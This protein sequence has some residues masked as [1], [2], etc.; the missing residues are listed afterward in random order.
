MVDDCTSDS[1]EHGDLA[2]MAQPSNADSSL[3]GALPDELLVEIFEQ[4]PFYNL[5]HTATF[6]SLCLVSKRIDLIARPYLFKNI[7]IR[8]TAKLVRLHRTI[9][10]NQHLCEHIKDLTIQFYITDQ[11][12]PAVREKLRAYWY[13]LVGKTGSKTSLSTLED[14]ELIGILCSELLAGAI[15]LSS[16]MMNINSDRHPNFSAFF[17]RVSRPTRPASTAEF[18]VFLPQLKNL[19]LKSIGAISVEVLDHFLD[20]PSLRTVLVWGDDGNWWR[21]APRAELGGPWPQLQGE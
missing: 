16:L 15:N 17:D 3:L 4:F 8:S 7:E 9:A 6:H 5:A 20:L 2:T 11:L 18:T 21:L 12:R 1:P 19:T 10:R 14:C 13:Q